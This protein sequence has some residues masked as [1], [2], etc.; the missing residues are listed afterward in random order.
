MERSPD[1]SAGET[2]GNQVVWNEPYKTRRAIQMDQSERTSEKIV[3][4]MFL[5]GLVTA[6]VMAALSPLVIW[7]VVLGCGLISV[8][9]LL[10]LKHVVAYPA[11]RTYLSLS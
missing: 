7:R 2:T 4:G 10:F 5:L 9:C 11:P 1:K 8:A 3:V 6:V